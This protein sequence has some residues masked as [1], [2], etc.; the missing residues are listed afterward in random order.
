MA[1]R[2]FVLGACVN[3]TPPGRPIPFLRSS[4]RG[5]SIRGVAVENILTGQQVTIDLETG[6]VSLA[7]PD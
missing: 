1:D 5:P 7:T 4:T 6:R 3:L 2:S